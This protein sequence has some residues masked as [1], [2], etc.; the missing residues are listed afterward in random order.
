MHMQYLQQQEAEKKFKNNDLKSS[1][2][3][4]RT[5]ISQQSKSTN[6]GSNTAGSNTE[7]NGEPE[8]AVSGVSKQSSNP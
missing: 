2:I 1:G 6:Y 7:S 3:K 4:N 8:S 5:L